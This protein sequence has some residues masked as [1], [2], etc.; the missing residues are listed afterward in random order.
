M[1]MFKRALTIGATVLSLS[2]TPALATDPARDGYTT[3]P[4]GVPPVVQGASATSGSVAPTTP[5]ESTGSALPFTGFDI[6]M[7]GGAAVLLTGLGFALRRTTRSD[8]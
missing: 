8:S 3:T 2:A 1:H 6:G 4:I 5:T 7:V